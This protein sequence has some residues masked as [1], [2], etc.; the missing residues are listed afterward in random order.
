MNGAVA[1]LAREDDSQLA[2]GFTVGAPAQFSHAIKLYPPG[3]PAN[4][5]P[6]NTETPVVSE[7][8]DE[9]VFTDPAETFYVQLRRLASLPSVEYSQQAHFG[10]FSDTEDAQAL[11]EAQ[12][13]LRTELAAARMK[14]DRLDRE[15]V[16]VEESLREVHERRATKGRSSAAAGGAASVSASKKAKI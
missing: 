14:L 11:L 1:S 13:F 12:K 9:V 6:N 3:T 4:A 2:H 10:R 8:Y 15:M 5:L 16:T 7:T